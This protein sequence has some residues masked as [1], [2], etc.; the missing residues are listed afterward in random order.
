[1]AFEI[2]KV[3]LDLKVRVLGSALLLPPGEPLNSQ[4]MG[5]YVGSFFTNVSKRI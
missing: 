4:G 3:C 5:V 2:N 1:M